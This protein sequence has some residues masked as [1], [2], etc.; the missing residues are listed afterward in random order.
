[1]PKPGRLEPPLSDRRDRSLVDILTHAA[2]EAD[3]PHLTAGINEYFSE[4]DSAKPGELDAG[5]IRLHVNHLRR[6]LG[7]AAD[8]AGARGIDVASRRNAHGKR[9]IRWRLP[10][11]AAA[12]DHGYRETDAAP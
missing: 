2:E 7:V 10:L 4:R 8:T 5:Q 9:G 11:L 12:A 3:A 6:R 1:V